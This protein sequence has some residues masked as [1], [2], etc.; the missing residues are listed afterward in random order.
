[1]NTMHITSNIQIP[2]ESY[3]LI[4]IPFFT[5]FYIVT[6]LA[7]ATALWHDRKFS[8]SFDAKVSEIVKKIVVNRT[9]G[10]RV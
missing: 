4:L 3:F 8:R 6:V 10:E 7:I 2:M 1:M 5:L 9:K